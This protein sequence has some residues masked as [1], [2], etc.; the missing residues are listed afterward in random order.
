MINTKLIKRPLVNKNTSNIAPILVSYYL[1]TDKRK[2]VL[3]ELKII[4]NNFSLYKYSIM[5]FTINYIDSLGLYKFYK[6][7]FPMILTSYIFQLFN[8]KMIS[9]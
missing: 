9:C 8:C 4:E 3:C 1:I 5:V 6:H 7:F 2:K